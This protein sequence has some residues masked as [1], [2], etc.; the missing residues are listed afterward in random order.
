MIYVVGIIWGAAA[1]LGLLLLVIAGATVDAPI[2]ASRCDGD[3]AALIQE[4]RRQERQQV[5]GI[6]YR[7]DGGRIVM[8]MGPDGRWSLFYEQSG[9]GCVLANGGGWRWSTMARGRNL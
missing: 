2:Q 7:S 5:A 9:R 3:A 6:G 1:A 8:T 4:A